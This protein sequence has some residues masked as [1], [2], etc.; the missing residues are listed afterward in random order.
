LIFEIKNCFLF[1]RNLGT[2]SI[3]ERILAAAIP[4]GIAQG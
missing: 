2:G 1:L 3:I 4:V